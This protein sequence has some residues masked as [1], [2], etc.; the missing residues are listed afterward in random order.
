MSPR[1]VGFP[2]ISRTKGFNPLIL[3]FL[4]LLISV[5]CA[6]QHKYKKIKAVPCPCE[7]ENRRSSTFRTYESTSKDGALYQRI[8]FILNPALISDD[9]Q[10][11]L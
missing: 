7:K 9:Q 5:S 10:V 1:R 8:V 3:M 4:I 11:R 2:V 6:T